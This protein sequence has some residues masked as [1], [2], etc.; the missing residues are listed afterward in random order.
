MGAASQGQHHG[1][2]LGFGHKGRD[3]ALEET[4]AALIRKNPGMKVCKADES[5]LDPDTQAKLRC[6]RA[7][8]GKD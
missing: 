4:K 2:A 5:L 8:T 6:A 3:D 7:A 1:G